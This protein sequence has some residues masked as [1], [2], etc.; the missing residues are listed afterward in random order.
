[1]SGQS[2][3]TASRTAGIEVFG[4]VSDTNTA[5]YG[6]DRHFGGMA[7]VDFSL[8]RYIPNYHGRLT[9]S[10]ELR[11]TKAPGTLVSE[12][13]L[14]GGVKVAFNSHHLHPYGAVL[15][16][17]GGINFTPPAPLEPGYVYTSDSSFLFLY[18]G[19]LTFD[20]LRDWSVLADYQHQSWNL[21][22]T[23]PITFTPQSVSLGVV[24]RVHLRPYRTR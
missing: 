20:V 18:G 15:F 3:D 24:Y 11:G 2:R 12:K 17:G 13:T 7:G 23:P 9:T 6:T 16:G 5:F 14:Q 10:I 21:G 19:G 22:F 8:F 4:A 1:L